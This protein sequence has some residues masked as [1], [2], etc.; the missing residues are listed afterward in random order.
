MEKRVDRLI[1]LGE[2][3][4]L[5]INL[6]PVDNASMD[7][8]DFI[9]KAYCVPYKS[10]IIT[11]ANAL[12]DDANNYVAKIDSSILGLGRVRLRITAQ[13]PD[14]DFE[15]GYRPSICEIDTHYIIVP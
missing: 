5:N 1:H 10:Q 6:P 8:Y 3:F 15:D 9:A 13:I 11:K 4:K 14:G 7:D 2:K 12:R